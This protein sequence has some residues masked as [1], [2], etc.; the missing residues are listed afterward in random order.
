[1]RVSSRAW[2]F[3]RID[4]ASRFPARARR[5]VPAQSCSRR[6]FGH[7][8]RRCS[9]YTRQLLLAREDAY[10]SAHTTMVSPDSW[11]SSAGS[12]R[13]TSLQRFGLTTRESFGLSPMIRQLCTRC[14]HASCRFSRHT[15]VCTKRLARSSLTSRMQGRFNGRLAHIPQSVGKQLTVV[16]QLHLPTGG[17]GCWRDRMSLGHHLSHGAYRAREPPIRWI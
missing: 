1:M 6:V 3:P 15:S 7:W 9:V 17:N 11:A 8:A 4:S 16:F 5:S 10:T 2:V 14:L 12:R 13:L